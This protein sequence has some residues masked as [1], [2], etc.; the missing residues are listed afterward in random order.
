MQFRVVGTLVLLGLQVPGAAAQ[1]SAPPNWAE[2]IEQA[3]LAAPP[4]MQQGATVL[5]YGGEARAEDPLTL[6]REGTNELICLA[7]DP[8]A[9]EF[10]VA[11]YH[12]SLDG[13]MALGRRLKAAGMG[14]QEIMDARY[15]ALEAG[16]FAM[17]GRASLFSISAQGG[18]EDLE[19]ARR[20]AVVYVP[21]ATAEELGLPA[22]PDGDSPWLM[23]PGTP[24]AHIMIGR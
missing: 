4:S 2:Q 9:P 14:R 15:A 21:G 24:W 8:G 6:L 16:E 1:E 23:L 19:G 11:C 20:L 17:P 3:V 13:F 22:R 7:D 10:H 12:R 5:G 18:P